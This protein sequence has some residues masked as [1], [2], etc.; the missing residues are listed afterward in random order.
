MA[1]E[2]TSKITNCPDCHVTPDTLHHQG[3]DVARC[4]R[5]GL[6][7]LGCGHTSNACNTRWTGRW[8]GEAECVEYG[9]VIDVGSDTEPLPDLN[10]LYALCD[11]DPNQQRMVLRAPIADHGG[12][13]PERN[14]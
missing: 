6:Q 11:W 13:H 3:C 14:T 10:R 5:T 12:E 8:P 4:A 1:A 7:R 2:P 9:L